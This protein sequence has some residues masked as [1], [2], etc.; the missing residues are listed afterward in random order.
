MPA[1]IIR[2]YLTESEAW[3]S[4]SSSQSS[5]AILK[6]GHSELPFSLAEVIQTRSIRICSEF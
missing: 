1:P 2:H 5:E 3:R 4:S 6:R